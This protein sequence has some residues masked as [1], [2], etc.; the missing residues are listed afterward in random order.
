[1]ARTSDPPPSQPEGQPAGDLPLTVPAALGWSAG[2]LVSIWFVLL[3]SQ[4]LR[5]GAAFDPVNVHGCAALVLSLSTYA[6][7]RLYSPSRSTAEA[8]SVRRT[9]PLFYPLGA[10]LGVLML[11]SASW[12][13]AWVER[14]FPFSPEEVETMRSFLPP[15]GL[16]PRAAYATLTVAV[17]PLTE[18]ML[19][20]GA[21]FRL[22]AKGVRS[23]V[24][25]VVVTALLFTLL[26][27]SLRSIV[28][29]L[30]SGLMLGVLRASSGSLVPSILAHAAF[31]GV[32]TFELL[33]GE[34][35][36]DA[37]EPPPPLWQGLGA[38]ALVAAGLALALLLGQ[39]SELAREARK[40]DEP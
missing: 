10:A 20:R 40:G 24:A 23:A 8:L 16:G 26:H 15:P 18:E 2:S 7:V 6:L 13:S 39:R 21:M 14:R 4:S 36:F 32:T 11:V 1:V 22:L 27:G 38:T 29:V 17:V 12:V 31:N 5:P 35:S 19:V 25:L 30:P 33:R 34:A 37:N 3:L 9:H 28:H